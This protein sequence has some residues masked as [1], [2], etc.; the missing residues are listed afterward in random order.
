[1]QFALFTS[2]AIERLSATELDRLLAEE[3]KP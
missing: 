3:P 2:G 1:V